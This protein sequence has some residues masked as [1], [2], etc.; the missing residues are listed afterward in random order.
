MW[1]HAINLSVPAISKTLYVSLLEDPAGGTCT[2]VW[3]EKTMTQHAI[4]ECKSGPPPARSRMSALQYTVS[5]YP[6]GIWPGSGCAAGHGRWCR[7]MCIQEKRASPCRRS[8][9]DAP[10]SP[11]AE[12]ATWGVGTMH[13]PASSCCFCPTSPPPA[14]QYTRQHLSGYLVRIIRW[15][16]CGHASKPPGRMR[17]S[18]FTNGSLRLGTRAS[19]KDF[20]ESRL[21]GSDSL[22]NG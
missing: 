22:M 19:R 14:K 10:H 9:T 13:G 17:V 7:G 15:L 18:E 8:C 1:T 3:T 16:E 21:A 20:L 12:A 5:R 4:D 6:C 11:Y 2:E